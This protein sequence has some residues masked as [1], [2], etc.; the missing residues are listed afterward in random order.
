[1]YI[2][3]GDQFQS[4]LRCIEVVQSVLVYTASMDEVSELKHGSYTR[5]FQIFHCIAASMWPIEKIETVKR[6]TH[7]NGYLYINRH[8]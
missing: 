2:S 5:P 8:S 4:I 7:P 3:I 6:H 1:M